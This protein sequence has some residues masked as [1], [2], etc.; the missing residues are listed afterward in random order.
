MM[1]GARPPGDPGK[2]PCLDSPLTA[3]LTQMYDVEDLA[4][5]NA[6]NG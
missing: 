4:A 3:A 1:T 6:E 2:Q 5:T